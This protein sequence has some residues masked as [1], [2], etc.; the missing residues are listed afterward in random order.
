MKS[1]ALSPL[2]DV[3]WTCRPDWINSRVRLAC[4]TADAKSGCGA[5]NYVALLIGGFAA[6]LACLAFFQRASAAVR[7]SSRSSNA[8]ATSVKVGPPIAESQRCN[9]TMSMCWTPRSTLLIALWPRDSSVER[10]SCVSLADFLASMRSSMRMSCGGGN[11]FFKGL[12]P[13]I[14]VAQASTPI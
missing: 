7:A 4:L 13:R 11:G 5:R 10:S 14:V 8:R 9:S 6:F 12:K 1:R 3:C 2:T